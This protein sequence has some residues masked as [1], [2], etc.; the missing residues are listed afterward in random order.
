MVKKKFK[1]LFK[2]YKKF[3][4]KIGINET[5]RP[6]NISIEKYLLIVKELEKKSN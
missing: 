2:D 3:I 5:C 1:I 6:Q 4:K